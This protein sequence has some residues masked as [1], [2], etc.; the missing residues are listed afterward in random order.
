M[1]HNIFTIAI[2]QENAYTKAALTSPPLRE[3]THKRLRQ[4][5]HPLSG[6]GWMWA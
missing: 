5:D 4:V 1:N 6:S 3:K 2:L